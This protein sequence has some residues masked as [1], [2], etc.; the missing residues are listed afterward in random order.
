MVSYA[1]FRTV[2]LAVAFV[3]TNLAFADLSDD[4]VPLR[5]DPAIEYATRP[6][7][8]PISVLNAEIEAGQGPPEIRWR[9]RLLAIRARDSED[10]NRITD[11]GL[12]QNQRPG[13][14]D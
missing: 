6:T 13:K 5:G 3:V 1:H 14:I 2:I 12:F 11:G 4:F 10:S 8:D 9:A 7:H